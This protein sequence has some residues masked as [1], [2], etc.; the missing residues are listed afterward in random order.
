MKIFIGYDPREAAVYHVC[1]QSIIENATQPVSIT[2][3]HQDL[4]GIDGQQDGS[5]AFI[6]SRYL[7]PH[8]CGYEGVALFIDGDMHLNADVKE[9]FDLFDPDKAVQVVKHDYDPT[10][11]K[12][13]G[14]PLESV[15]LTYPRKNWSSVMLF[16]CGHPS[17]QI[18][19]PGLVSEAG[20]RFLHRFEWLNDDEI[21]TL[22]PTWNHL[23]GEQDEADAKLVHFT[24]GAPGFKHYARCEHAWQWNEYLLKALNMEGERATEIVRRATWRSSQITQPCRQQLRIT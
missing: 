16:N 22:P 11:V 18:L 7:V 6:Y 9:L 19:T 14:T 5:N 23:V 12:Y 20:G 1:S 21:G 8:L 4:L 17:N 2:P 10:H 24:L 3:L 15:N 13:V